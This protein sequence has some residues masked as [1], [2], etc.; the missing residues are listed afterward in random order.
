MTE[1]D[2]FLP[3]AATLRG[4][5]RDLMLRG[6]IGMPKPWPQMTEAEQTATA[7]YLDAMAAEIIARVC[8][9][10]HSQGR[11]HAVCKVE[12]VTVNDA[13]RAILSMNLQQAAGLIPFTK[14]LVTVM[15]L[16]LNAFM[17]QRAPAHVMPDEPELPMAPVPEAAPASEPLPAAVPPAVPKARAPRKPATPPAKKVG[18]PFSR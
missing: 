2:K 5:L 7:Q 14:Q 11:Q 15:P 17:G 3:A 10:V 4:D 6:V 18:S 13:C 1:P 9:L 12:K 8:V 16:D